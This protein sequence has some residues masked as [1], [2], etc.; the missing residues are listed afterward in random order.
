MMLSNIIVTCLSFVMETQLAKKMDALPNKSI[1]TLTLG[2]SL[3]H[4]MVD[5]LENLFYSQNVMNVNTL[6]DWELIC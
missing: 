6:T 2:Q 5:T 3:N 1:E 4:S